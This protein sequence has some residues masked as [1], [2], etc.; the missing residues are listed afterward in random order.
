MPNHSPSAPYVP[1]ALPRDY[2][3]SV[4]SLYPSNP[5]SL[6]PYSVL[7]TPYPANGSR[8]PTPGEEAMRYR[9]RPQNIS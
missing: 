9:N 3:G 1:N 6:L 4:Y 5:P 8:Q 7:G 2:T